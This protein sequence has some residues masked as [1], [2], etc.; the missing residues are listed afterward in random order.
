MRVIVMALRNLK[1]RLSEKNQL[2]PQ[3]GSTPS[4]VGS[5]VSGVGKLSAP[6]LTM[7]LQMTRTSVYR[8]VRT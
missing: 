8:I 7:M 1:R 3:I 6:S 2:H 5:I 4:E